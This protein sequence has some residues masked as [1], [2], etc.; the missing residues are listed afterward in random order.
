MSPLPPREGVDAVRVLLPES[1]ETVEQHLL[2]RLPQSAAELVRIFAACGMVD[3]AGATVQPTDSCAGQTVWYHR[4]FAPEPAVPTDVP[5]L[6]Q[7]QHLLVVDKPHGLPTTPRGAFVRN[8]ALSLLRHT[9]QEP[10]LAPAHRLDRL[11]AGVLL[12]TRDPQIRGRMQRQFQN[13]I[14]DKVYEAVVSLPSRTT[15]EAL[16]GSRESRIQKLRGSLQAVEV[17]GPV[18]AVTRIEPLIADPW[19]DNHG[20]WAALRLHPTTGQ[21]HQLRVHLNALGTPIRWDPLYPEVL[22]PEVTDAARP[23]QLLARSLSIRHPVTGEPMTFTSS[24]TLVTL[25]QTPPPTGA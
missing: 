17:D 15:L 19:S 2:T 1:A 11:T 6:Y 5:V 24:R 21:T 10:D 16:P 23:L 22:D 7:D 14:T 9:R 3:S 12:L 18:N 25:E 8:T 4:P 20:A 13:R